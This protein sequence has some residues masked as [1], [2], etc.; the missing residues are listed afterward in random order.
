M[1]YQRDYETAAIRVH[2]ESS[3]CIHTGVCLRTLPEVFDTS[4]RPWV[5]IEAADVDAIAGAV[6]RCPSGALRY[7]RLDGG[8]GE[9]PQRPTIVVP[10]ENGPLMLVGDLDVRDAD[11][12]QIT[13]ETRLTLCRCG[14]SR[15]QPFCDNS[16]RRR[17]WQSGPTTS[18]PSARLPPPDEGAAERPTEIVAK[19]DASL[20]L[21]GQLR[22]HHSDGERLADTSQALLCRCGHSGHKPFCD[23][24]HQLAEF[25]SSPP[26]IPRQRLTADTP[27]AFTANP[28]VPEPEQFNG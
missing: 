18:G 24:S 4:R 7:Q 20:Q 15:N 10:I 1:P 17:G 5:D 2:W 3:R 6:E 25:T 22:I 9:E 27:A 8:R 16:H 28:G 19:R 13:R 21:R 12:Q 11:G 26:E 23:G 14:L